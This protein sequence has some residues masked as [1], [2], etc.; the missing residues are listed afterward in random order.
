MTVFSIYI[1]NK[2]G[3]LIYQYDH[4]K[5]SVEMEKTFSYPLDLK[6][7]AYS[8]QV[9][10]VFGQRDG[11]QVGHVVL[12]VNGK[13]TNGR[14]LED[15]NDVI[16]TIANEKNYPISIKFGRPKLTSNQKIMMASMFHSLYAISVQLSP[17]HGSSGIQKLE[18]DTFTLHCNQ[19]A[20]GVKF[21]VIAEPRQVG[22]DSLLHRLY[23][24]Y[25]DFALKNPFY[26]LEMPIR[27]EQF[28]SHVL[29]AIESTEKTGSAA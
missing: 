18:T 12:A 19:T 5:S 3:G 4:Q 13:Q 11:I 20:T 26:S 9:S 6:L 10:V 27:T 8:D 15:G 14:K 2:A 21:V 1:I 22:I 29:S 25:S 24:I 28:D 17:V 7:E 16:E 23:L